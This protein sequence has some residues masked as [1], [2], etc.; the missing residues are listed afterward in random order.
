MNIS[1]V[2]AV[3]N[4]VLN[5]LFIEVLNDAMG[6]AIATDITF[7]VS[8]V[9]TVNVTI[10]LSGMKINLRRHLFMFG[11]LTV[12]A[13]IL[14][15]TQNYFLCLFGLVLILILNIETLMWA[16]DKWKNLLRP[17]NKLN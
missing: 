9:L 16:K 7:F 2:A 4:I 5:G 11:I 13:V 17:Q 15:L 6:A 1:T 10:K 14:V 8:Y 12:Q 3:T